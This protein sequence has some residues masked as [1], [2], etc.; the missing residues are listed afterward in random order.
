MHRRFERLGKCGDVTVIDDYAHHP[1]EI[2]ATLSAA[3]QAFAGRVIAIFQP[4]LFSRTRDL[5]EDFAQA[6][7]QADIVLIAPIYPARE[8]PI[9]GV[10][11]NLL[12]DRIVAL[13]PGKSVVSLSSLE[14]G[15]AILSHSAQ[16]GTGSDDSPVLPAL[17]HG[18][19]I[20]TIGAGDV[21]T[22]G[23]ALVGSISD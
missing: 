22:V 10:T 21:N 19:V 16:G 13:S 5:H 4:H 8:A 3:R 2:R 20:I 14:E 6:F 11:H 9:P 1:T 23:Q 7:A 12:T 17:H 18:D 15:I